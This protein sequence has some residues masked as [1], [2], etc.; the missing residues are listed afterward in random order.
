MAAG[1]KG[2][3]AR[4][5]LIL[6]D[7]HR[8]VLEALAGHLA[9]HYDIVGTAFNVSDLISLARRREASCLLLD[10]EMP[11][12]NGLELIPVLKRLHAD[13]KIIIVTMLLDRGPHHPCRRRAVR[14]AGVVRMRGL[15]T[16]TD[17]LRRYPRIT[18]HIICFSL[19]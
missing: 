3:T 18:S 4:P 17:H 15:S 8:M 11:E 13:L 19:G 7:D 2:D 9:H 5:R 6:A 14:R 16:P 1:Q 12:K 10:F